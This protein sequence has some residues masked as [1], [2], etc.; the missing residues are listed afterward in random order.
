M[1]T[2]VIPASPAE[3]EVCWGREELG[4][5]V[6][7][8]E[9]P[10]HVERVMTVVCKHELVHRAEALDRRNKAKAEARGCHYDE[11]QHLG[12]VERYLQQSREQLA[13]LTNNNATV[14]QK[15]THKTRHNHDK[16]PDNLKNRRQV[17]NNNADE[18]QKDAKR[19]SYAT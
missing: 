15:E 14:C 5:L 10:P 8:K 7:Q 2:Q 12:S 1:H 19:A 3:K 11:V 6:L 18:V 13:S 4:E 9:L 17:G 16:R